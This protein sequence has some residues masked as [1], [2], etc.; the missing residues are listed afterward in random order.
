MNYSTRDGVCSTPP[1]STCSGRAT[2]PHSQRGYS[3]ATTD[4]DRERARDIRET[5]SFRSLRE[6]TIIETGGGSGV[7]PRR[8]R[9]RGHDS[10]PRS[11]SGRFYL[12]SNRGNTSAPLSIAPVKKSPA[13][14]LESFNKG[15]R[16]GSG[17][18]AFVTRPLCIFFR[19]Q[20]TAPSGLCSK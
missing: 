4:E 9:G 6:L 19:L 20:L 2:H 12:G 16:G 18:A 14:L 1:L 10:Y 13:C 8:A 7:P 5:F 15:R 17:F 3:R 11:G